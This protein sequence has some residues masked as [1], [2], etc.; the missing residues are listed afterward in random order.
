MPAKPASPRLRQDLVV[1]LATVG[2]DGHPHAVPVWFWWDGSAFLV[3]SVPGQKVEDI[4]QNPSVALHLNSD[5]EGGGVLRVDGTARIDPDQPPA[6]QVPSYLRKYREQIRGLGSTPK[7]FA[8]KYHV[9]IRIQ[10]TRF[11]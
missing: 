4:R 8:E 5:P 2:P 3:Y 6:H 9:A 10:P 1:W 11:H 7:V